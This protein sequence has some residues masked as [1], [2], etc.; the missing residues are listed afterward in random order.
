ML[1]RKRAGKS[2]TT[3]TETQRKDC[4]F[5][6]N[7]FDGSICNS[8]RFS[9]IPGSPIKPLLLENKTSDR[10]QNIREKRKSHIL[11]DKGW[12]DC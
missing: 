10:L 1:R 4:L 2:V 3:V 5:L 9:S 8:K 7:C 6:G 12:E 11:R